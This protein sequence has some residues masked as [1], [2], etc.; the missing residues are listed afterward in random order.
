MQKDELVYFE[1]L[2]KQQTFALQ[3][4][5]QKLI[6]PPVLDLQRSKG[7][8]TLETDVCDRQVDCVLLQKQTERPEK[9]IGNCLRSLSHAES[10]YETTLKNGLQWFGLYLYLH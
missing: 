4:L 9:P 8:C 6:K 7:T 5:Q 2:V 3:A 10:S 1:K